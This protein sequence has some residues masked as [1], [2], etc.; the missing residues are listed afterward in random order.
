M[1]YQIKQMRKIALLLISFLAIAQIK[2][3]VKVYGWVKDNKNKPL[4]N[5]S[6]TMLNTYDGATTDSVGNFSF[7]T[8]EK[9]KQNVEAKIVGYKVLVQTITIEKENIQLQFQLK[10]E[11]SELKA[12]TVTAGSFE[13]GDKKKAATVL[14]ALDIYTTGGANADIT[15]AVK[16]LPGAQQI[17]EQEGLFV[18]GGTG[19]ETKQMMDG[20]VINNPFFS[21]A[22]DIA[23][24]GRF[25]PSLFKGNIFSTGGY[26]ALYGQA[27]SSV[28]LLE[29]IDL[30]Q[31][32]EASASISTVFV[33]A[34]LQH[35]SKNKK[36][37]YGVNYGYTNLLPYF[38]I[39]KQKPDYFIMPQFHTADANF[40]IKTKNGGMLKYFTAF[41]NSK[42]GL[43]N[44]NIDSTILKD[45]FGLKNT[46]WYNNLSYKQT[47]Q[48]GWKM[49]LGLSYSI[50]VDDIDSKIQNQNNTN[51]TTSVWYIDAKNF[52]LKNTQTLA[53]ARAVFEKKLKGISALRVGT[54]YWYNQNKSK[55]N[56]FSS[57]LK[58]NYNA[59]FAETDI[60][61]TNAL[62]AKAGLRFEHSSIIN[63]NNVAPRLSLAYKTGTHGQMS[64]SFGEFYQTPESNQLLNTFTGNA[65]QIDFTKATH[66]LINYIKNNSLQTFRVEAFYKQYN[67]LVK[68]VPDTNNLGN[69][70][71]KGF[72][73]FWRDKKSIK[74]IDYWISYSYVD[75][76]RD[77][78]NYPK[79]MNPTFAAP[80]TLSIVTKTFITKLKTGFNLTYNFATGRNYYNLSYNN[81]LG[82]YEIKDEGKTIN[83]SNLGFS[84]NWLPN[85]GKP[86]AKTNYVIVASV[87]NV[88]NQNQVF[89]YRYSYNGV[90][91]VA[92]TPPAKQFYFIG[93]FFSWGV[94]K[95]QDAIN[96]N[97]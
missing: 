27:L 39:V 20:M 86:K 46:N 53:Q 73:I 92:V 15:A 17:G 43:R 91:K 22:P 60:Y 82:K 67:N 66:Y 11:V 90:N 13:A 54:E 83:Y 30:P 23:T 55:Y 85:L 72:E 68:T 74:Y 89:G 40:R 69:G 1:C 21:G 42:L 9:G 58:E 16:T 79:Q 52:L 8:Y 88:L 12:V 26:S 45:A 35:L 36:S 93:A 81:I 32:S 78:L 33:G 56:S 96:N 87:T 4:K 10:E 44:A 2:A 34:G 71:A 47:L 18:R 80:H 95:T 62:A 77:F 64:L 5:V 63:K 50:N 3:Q 51:V 25:S 65:K 31:R 49:Q 59:L 41:S 19:A 7:K 37:S 24:R 76:K 48:K 6:I 28:L 29:S 97:L 61:I 94:D 14:S 57:N 84:L 75:T 70:Y 38:S